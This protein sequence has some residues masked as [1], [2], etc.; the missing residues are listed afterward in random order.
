M[1]IGFKTDS[2]GVVTGFMAIWM[3]ACGGTFQ[4]WRCDKGL[5]ML[6]A[7]F[8]TMSLLC[9]AGFTQMATSAT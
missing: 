6:S 3:G 9:Y 1:F 7:L 2:F 5:W 4:A 8:L